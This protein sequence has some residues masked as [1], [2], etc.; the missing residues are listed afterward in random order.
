[1]PHF[2]GTHIAWKGCPEP[3]EAQH[4]T[5]GFQASFS[6]CFP[7]VFQRRIK[8]S[9]NKGANKCA[10]HFNPVLGTSAQPLVVKT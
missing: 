4:S 5:N 10:D 2:M 6:F 8:R 1:M 7:H 9:T 3:L